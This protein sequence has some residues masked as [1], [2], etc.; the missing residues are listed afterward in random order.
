MLYAPACY[1][2]IYRILSNYNA[3]RSMYETALALFAKIK[4]QC[5]VHFRLYNNTNKFVG[6]FEAHVTKEP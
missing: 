5:H 4:T 1:V 3:Y 6:L 2:H